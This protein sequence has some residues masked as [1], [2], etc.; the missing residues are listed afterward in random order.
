MYFVKFC[1]FVKHYT[2]AF[3]FLTQLPQKHWA[4]SI[5]VITFKSPIN[6]LMNE[7]IQIYM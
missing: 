6:W 4:T 2:D 7:T 3:H 5:K 1:T